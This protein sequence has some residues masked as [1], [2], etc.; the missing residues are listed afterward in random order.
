LIGVLLT[1]SNI[2]VDLIMSMVGINVTGDTGCSSIWDRHVIWDVFSGIQIHLSPLVVNQLDN[3][4]QVCNEGSTTT[5]PLQYFFWYP[6]TLFIALRWPC[7]RA[8]AKQER[9]FDA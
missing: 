5:L 3:S 2:P 9:L 7:L 1:Y 8:A 6:K 4:G